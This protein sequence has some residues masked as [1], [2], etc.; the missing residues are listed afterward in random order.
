M[1]A[2]NRTEIDAYAKI[3]LS[4]DILGVREDGFHLVEMILMSIPLFDR[5]SVTSEK[6]MQGNKQNTE[7][8]LSCSDK[9]LKCSDKN[10]A[11]RAA[12]LM[13]E[14][15]PDTFKNVGSVNIFIDKRIPVG[16]GLGGSSA[17]GA[18]VIK[19]FNR[20]FTMGLSLE[21]MMA[22]GG[23][24][25]S[26]V[27]FQ[28]MEGTGLCTGTGTDVRK[29]R[30]DLKGFLL[31]CSPSYGLDTGEMYR[32]Y[33][34]KPAGFSERPDNKK[35]IELVEQGNLEEIGKLQKNVLE[36]PAFYFRPELKEMKERL[37]KCGACGAMMSGSGSCVYGLFK[38]ESQALKAAGEMALYHDCVTSICDISRLN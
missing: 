15:Y 14:T 32:K 29:L 11:M 2:V 26:D 35:L 31:I 20:H 24:L 9:R 37:V 17:D 21:E 28:I 5:I 22:L 19:A 27:P 38:R 18:G 4:L 23:K 10:I 7:I 34:E 16:G 33:D 25:G 13:I 30:S 8:M 36:I 12:K 3:N 1:E 6:K